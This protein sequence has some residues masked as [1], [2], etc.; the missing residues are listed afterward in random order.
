MTKTHRF[1]RY[2]ILL[3]GFFAAAVF[4]ADL[5]EAK[6]AGLIGERADGLLGLVVTTAPADVVELVREVNDKRL[7]EYKR[8]AEENNLSIDQVRALAGKKAIEKT[9]PGGWVL[10][11]GGWQQK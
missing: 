5:G 11:N 8:I 9:E 7:T 4:A 2:T 3:I 1:A 10:V 6:K